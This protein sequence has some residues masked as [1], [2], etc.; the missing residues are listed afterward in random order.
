MQDFK[1][2]GRKT[3]NNKL[4]SNCPSTKRAKRRFFSN[5]GPRLQEHSSAQP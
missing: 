4:G 1:A 2:R 3:G 5:F